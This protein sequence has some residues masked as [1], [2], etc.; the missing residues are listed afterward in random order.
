[1]IGVKRRQGW[2]RKDGTRMTKAYQYYQCGSRT[3][4]SRCGYHS[5]R[6][7]EIE[8]EVIDKL[9]N[10][11]ITIR[12]LDRSSLSDAFEFSDSIVRIVKKAISVGDSASSVRDQFKILLDRESTT[13]NKTRRHISKYVQ[14]IVVENDGLAIEKR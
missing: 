7:R 13:K 1:M 9:E 14:R 4:Q 10:E 11:G 5:R 3:N 6:A 12:Q 8:A 2:E